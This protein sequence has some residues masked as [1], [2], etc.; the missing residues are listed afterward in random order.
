MEVLLGIPLNTVKLTLTAKTLNEDE[1][2]TEL[3][4]TMNLQDIIQARVEAEFWI[5]ENGKWVINEK[6][7]KGSG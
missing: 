6:K 7:N 2:F 1:T 3:T 4:T 5:D